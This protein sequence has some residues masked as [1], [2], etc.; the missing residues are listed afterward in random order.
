VQISESVII[1]CGYE[2][3]AIDKIQLPIQTL[4]QVT[5]TNRTGTDEEKNGGHT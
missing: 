3:Q 5:N 2:L 4:F 1:I